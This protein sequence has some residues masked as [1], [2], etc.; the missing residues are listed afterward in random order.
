MKFSQFG[1]E[2]GRLVIYFHGAPGAPEE[3][4]IFDQEGKRRGLS[5]ICFDRFSIDTA[6]KQQ[7]YYTL[8]AEQISKLAAGKPVDMIGFSNGAF[9]ALQVCRHLNN[10]VNSLHLVSAAAPLEAGDFLDAMAAK[11]IFQLAKASPALFL[12][13]SYWQGLLAWLVPDV[14]FRMLFASAAGEDQTLV[15]DSHFQA[16]IFKILKSCFNGRIPGYSRDTQA[17]LQPWQDTLTAITVDTHIWHGEVDNWT[18]KPMAD[19]LH[20]ALPACTAIKIY[21]GASHYSCLYRAAP[22]ICAVLTLQSRQLGAH[23]LD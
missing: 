11:P 17:Y 1:A 9:I 16:S 12:L 19:Y 3:C 18:P 22:E 20:T 6:I 10:A 2:N 8:L 21:S 15:A 5:F 14:L 4:R 23:G 7:A 13:L